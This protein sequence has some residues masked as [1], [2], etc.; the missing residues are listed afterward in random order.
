VV[1]SLQ[2]GIQGVDHSASGGMIYMTIGT[3]GQAIL[4]FSFRNLKV[5]N[6]GI[7]DMNNLL[8]MPLRWAQVAWYK[9]HNSLFSH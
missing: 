2:V 8:S 3:G 1:V 5:C 9:F 6:V 7:T 4:E